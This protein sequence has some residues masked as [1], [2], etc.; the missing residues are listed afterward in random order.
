MVSI[1]STT[2]YQNEDSHG[3][4]IRDIALC[5]LVANDP[6]ILVIVLL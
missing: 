3:I 5:R 1:F 4:A 2:R 6:R